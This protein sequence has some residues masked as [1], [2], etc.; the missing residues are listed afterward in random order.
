MAQQIYT[1]APQNLISVQY[2]ADVSPYLQYWDGNRHQYMYK[3]TELQTLGMNAGRVTAVAF[4]IFSTAGVGN[5]E[6]F[7]VRMGQTTRRNQYYAG[8]PYTYFVPILPGEQAMTEVFVRTNMTLQPGWFKHDF[9]NPYQWD[10]VSN[11]IVEVCRFTNQYTAN[12][13]VYYHN[14][15]NTAGE[16]I[17]MWQWMDNY[18]GLGTCDFQAALATYIS[19]QRPNIQF[20]VQSG[21]E[22]SFPDDVD[23]RRILR[24][25]DTYNGA[26]ATHPMPSIT[27]RQALNRTISFTY[28]IIGPLPATTVVYEGRQAGNP[29]ITYTGTAN[30]LYTHNVTEAVGPAAG[31]GGALVTSTIPGGTYRLDVLYQDGTYQQ[32]WQKEFNIAFPNDLAVREIRSPLKAPQKYPRGVGIPVSCRVQNVGLNDQNDYDVTAVIKSYPAGVTLYTQ[33]LH[34]SL[35][36]KTGEY[37]TFDFPTFAAPEV[38]EYSAQFCVNNVVPFDEQAINDCLPAAGFYIFRVLYNEEVGASEIVVPRTSDQYYANRPF[39]PIGRV[40]N[41]GILDLTDVPVTM[42][43]YR[44]PGRVQVYQSKKFVPDVSATEPGNLADQIFAPFTPTEAGQYEACLRTEMP[45]DGLATNNEVCMQFTVNPNLSGTYTIGVLKSG[46]PRNYTTIK[47][48]VDDLYRKGVGGPVTFEFTDASYLAGDATLTAPAVDFRTTIIGA[49]TTNTITF[50]ADLNRSL[51]K[52]SVTITLQSAGGSGFMFGQSYGSV[53]PNSVRASFPNTNQWANSAGC[54][55]F[56]GGLQKSIRVQMSST[57]QF[58]APFYLND[59]SKNI[60]I[61]NCLITSTGTPS[62]QTSIPSINFINNQ[63][64]YEPD[65]RTISGQTVT[66]T[67]G[68]V[69]RA[70]LPLG[71]D[72]MTNSER[73]DTVRSTDNKFVGN[74]ITNFGY[75]IVTMGIGQA[76]KTGVNLYLPYYNSGTEVSGNTIYNVRRAGVFAA[77]EDGISIRNN[78]VYNVGITATGGTQVS[79]SGIIAG[80]EKRYHNINLN[81]DGNEISGVDGDLWSR[82]ITVEQ[83]RNIYPSVGATGSNTYFPAV[84]EATTIKNN[85]VWGLRRN[86]AAANMAGIHIYTQRNQT[87]TGVNAILLPS[88]NNEGYFTKKDMIVNNTVLMTNDGV[89]NGSG[90]V[91][92]IGVQH[93][94]GTTVKNNA[95][96]MQGTSSASTL[97]HSALT[98]EGVDLHGTADAALQLKS[99][100]NAFELGAAGLARVFEITNNSVV[101]STGSQTE[102]ENLGQ[103]RSWNRQDPNS[104]IGAIYND[105]QLLGVSPN[106]RLRVKSN[107][108]PKGSVLSNRGERIL[109]V[110]TDVDGNTRGSAQANYD[111]GADEFDGQNFVSDLEVIDIPK[112][113]IY[114]S[115]VGTAS[116]AEYVMTTAP[117]DASGRIRN[118]GSLA[119]NNAP[120]RVRVFLETSASNNAGLATPIWNATPAVDR[121]TNVNLNAAETKDVAM[122][123]QNFTPSVYA[124]LSGYTVPARFSSM[125]NNVTPRYRVE[126]TV[127]NDENNTNNTMTKVV[128]YFLQRSGTKILVSARGSA[129]DLSAAPTAAQI[130]GRLNTDSLIAYLNKVGFVNNMSTGEITYDV[131]ERSAWEERAVD[132]SMYRTMFHSSD[133]SKFTR[134]ERD[135]LRAFIASGA[136]GAKKNLALSSQDVVRNHIGMDPINDES[137]VRTVLRVTN[138]SPGT[139]VPSTSNYSGKRVRGVTIA[140][141]TTETVLAT[142]FAGDANP[143]PALVRLYSDA[144]TPGIAGASYVYVLGDRTTTDSLMGSAAASLTHNMV[145]LGVDWRHWQYTGLYTGG[146]RVIRGIIDFFETNGGT[147]VP[148]E[149]VAFDADARGTTV[150]V[151]W[152]TASEQNSDHFVIERADIT[153]GGSESFEEVATMAAAGNST[154][155]RDYLHRDMDV[156]PGTY[157]YRLRMVDLDGSVE[158]SQA[159]QVV[160]GGSDAVTITSAQP[161]PMTGMTTVSINFP[162]AA[163]AR[164]ELVDVAGH[165]VMAIH[166]GTVTAGLNTM[167]FDA[168]ALAAGAYTIVVTTPDGTATLPVVARR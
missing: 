68:I 44:L 136:Q 143:N 113:S 141:N 9:T 38:G 72:G 164:V 78:R 151:A 1:V 130:A 95:V 158:R 58:R 43:I 46:Q 69:S 14:V 98:Y 62:Y 105:H 163:D 167:Q 3:A 79:A 15:A 154:V 127:S 125:A 110:T 67:A 88:T 85:V 33:T 126:I 52:G 55:R 82:G 142:G 118:N 71:R 133:P 165:S 83:V 161:M 25:G 160:V 37:E 121:T 135:D 94:G 102:Y 97:V 73:I 128:R 81:I 29:T 31:T 22:Q 13:R 139:P 34:S 152:T 23:P 76:I 89:S 12:A 77:Y 63:F 101:I 54:I 131:F 18:P 123:I 93:S 122:G 45:G 40:V 153:R 74:E 92:A 66:Y 145:Y 11:L 53:N 120:V 21:I 48:A 159:V 115:S 49:S 108:T 2:G 90:L 148:V 137:F 4:N 112:P 117:V 138:Q 134:Y 166:N 7:R 129:N 41:G 36:I 106:Q 119:K 65:V 156:T 109:S 47:D 75:G 111:L 99:D 80:G 155:T 144:S 107:P 59:G 114:R 104:V 150:D 27:F 86:G 19:N 87:A 17:S 168:S 146:D 16:Y 6:T 10:G 103:W 24:R 39:E 35:N 140:R 60:E 100:R 124:S 132:Y 56:D 147:V 162:S 61:R 116:D 157:L 57:S 26:D 64:T 84:D 30:G 8:V 20:Y 70:K 91:T 51:T 149:L 42:T 96:I 32:V 5:I 28:K 50:K